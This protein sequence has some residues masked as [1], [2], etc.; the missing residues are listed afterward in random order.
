MINMKNKHNK[1]R[2]KSY[3]QV[4]QKI[5]FPCE[6]ERDNKLSMCHRNIVKAYIIHNG[7]LP[8]ELLW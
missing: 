8:T 3:A 6:S 7:R 5:D 2:K 1:H 4:K